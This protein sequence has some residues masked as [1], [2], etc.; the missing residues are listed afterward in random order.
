M[1]HTSELFLFAPTLT[2]GSITH[3]GVLAIMS[4][5][6]HEFSNRGL[7][8]LPQYE[9]SVVLPTPSLFNVKESICK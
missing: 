7:L 9:G 5:G 1:L 8:S 6:C 4:H 2:K 3:T